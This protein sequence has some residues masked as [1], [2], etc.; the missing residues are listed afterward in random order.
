MKQVLDAQEIKQALQKITREILEDEEVLEKVVLV[1]ITTRGVPLA[2]RISSLLKEAKGIE[3]PTGILDMTLYRDDLSRLSTHPIVKRTEIPFSIDEKSVF[4]V[5]DVLY[6][7]RTIRGALNA[8]FDLG[9]PD[10]VGLA[11]LVDRGG[12]EIPIEASVVGLHVEAKKGENVV[13]KLTETDRE[14]GVF[15]E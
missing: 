10:R 1:G 15:V 12:R 3:V 4:L 14:E 7:G 13:V 11:V 2:Q 5:D 9:R 8:L 6:T